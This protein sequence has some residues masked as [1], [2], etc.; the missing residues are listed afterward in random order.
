MPKQTRFQR[1]N[2]KQKAEN[3]HNMVIAEYVMLKYAAIADDGLKC[4]E[5]LKKNWANNGKPYKRTKNMTGWLRGK[6]NTYIET[7]GVLQQEQQQQEQPA[8]V[9]L[10]QVSQPEQPVEVPQVSQPEQPVEVPQVPQPEQPVEVP[11]VPQPE[12]PIEEAA[13]DL[14]EEL[15]ARVG[16]IIQMLENEE[17]E[18]I[19]VG[20]GV[21]VTPEYE[22]LYPEEYDEDFDF[23]VDFDLG[24]NIE[25]N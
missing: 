13:A 15:D 6:I 10:P 17:D 23:D 11:Q 7:V 3:E 16:E 25:I 20:A 21:M 5:W 1:M 24:L 4:Y 2:K 8:E 9:S 22:H 12:Q 18:G 14:L 19:E